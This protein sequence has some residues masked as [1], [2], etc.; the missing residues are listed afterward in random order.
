MTLQ[1]EASSGV[2]ANNLS[3]IVAKYRSKRKFSR[4]SQNKFDDKYYRDECPVLSH[5]M[6]PNATSRVKRSLARGETRTNYKHALRLVFANGQY[7]LTREGVL[8]FRRN[9]KNPPQIIEINGYPQKQLIL[10]A[11]HRRHKPLKTHSRNL[12]IPWGLGSVILHVYNGKFFQQI[13]IRN[14]NHQGRLGELVPTRQRVKHGKAGKG[15]T[16]GTKHVELK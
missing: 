11:Y 8:L 15:A 6:G 16:Q 1:Q 4:K 9:P 2:I 10:N 5:H 13:R 14:H 3:I 12:I 7:E